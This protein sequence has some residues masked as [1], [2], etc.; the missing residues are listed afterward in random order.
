M[1]VAKTKTAHGRLAVQFEQHSITRQYEALVQRRPQHPHGRI[2]LPLGTDRTN[3]KRTS[4]HTLHPKASLTEYYVEEVFG[5]AAAHMVL[6]RGPA[7][8]TRYEPIFTRLVTLSWEIRPTVQNLSVRWKDMGC[9][10]MLHAHKLGFHH[11][12]TERYC[13]FT[14]KPPADFH[15]L[16]DELRFQDREG[17]LRTNTVNSLILRR[18]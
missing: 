6:T 9:R 16:S 1:V 11:P 17:R 15:A 10:V 18:V 5:A 8:P 7:A 4:A 12:L 3:V 13:E 2:E 14:V